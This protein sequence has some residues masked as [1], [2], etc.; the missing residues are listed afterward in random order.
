MCFLC[1]NTLS[2]STTWFFI[3]EHNFSENQR[4]YVEGEETRLQQTYTN[5]IKVNNH[6]YKEKQWHKNKHLYNH[7]KNRITTQ[8]NPFC[9]TTYAS[10]IG[11][12]KITI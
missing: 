9:I 6:R 8:Y 2:L 11:V 4:N 1:F 12:I 7:N 5:S 3:S 10:L